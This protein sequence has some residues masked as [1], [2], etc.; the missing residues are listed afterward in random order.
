MLLVKSFFISVLLLFPLSAL[1]CAYHVGGESEGG[2][3]LPGST[4]LVL[5]TFYA[6][7]KG[8]IAKLDPLEGRQGFLR[9][10]WWLNLF[11]QKLKDAGIK[12]AYVV[13][14]DVQLWS[15]M[16]E[17]AQFNRGIDTD[18]PR[19]R[20]NS[21][22]LSEAALHA[23]VSQAIDIPQAIDLGVMTV[24]QDNLGIT[25]KLLLTSSHL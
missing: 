11:F 21:I 18:I 2:A 8:S 4:D 12:D 10:S 13:I 14:A 24:Y 25:E 15:K 16:G 17:E 1:A 5:N 19:D 6:Q 7:Q 22:V 23:L 9:V 20:S 3:I